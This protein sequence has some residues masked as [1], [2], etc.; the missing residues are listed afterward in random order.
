MLWRFENTSI[1]D[2]LRDLTQSFE[3]HW[4]SHLRGLQL[5][6]CWH[7][8]WRR[9]EAKRQSK[10]IRTMKAKN[11]ILLFA[12][13]A[14]AAVLYMQGY[15]YQ[16]QVRPDEQAHITGKLIEWST[17]SG[18][19]RRPTPTL[20]FTI[21]GFSA[22]L[23]D[24]PFLFGDVMASRV[25]VDFQPGAA[26]DVIAS[27]SEIANPSRPALAK[28]LRI[29]WINGLSVN[30]RQS[31]DLQAALRHQTKNELWGYVLLAASLAFFVYGFVGWQR[32][33]ARL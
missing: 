18:S 26:I 25:S 16:H 27:R 7:L 19:R 6:M 11:V 32:Q 4:G 23:R 15:N 14:F 29:V 3:G 17:I 33:R 10:T 31:F 24:D 2:G 30:G 22:D 9:A 21:S 12:G 5:Y 8:G 28:D 20:R 1:D 13:L